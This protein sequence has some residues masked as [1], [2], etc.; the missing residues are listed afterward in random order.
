[1]LWVDDWLGLM[2]LSSQTGY[3]VPVLKYSTHYGTTCQKQNGSD[4]KI[5]Q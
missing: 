3:I 1:M 4:T 5:P 2:T